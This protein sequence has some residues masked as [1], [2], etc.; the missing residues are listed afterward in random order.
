MNFYDVLGITHSASKE[1]I[2]KAYHR[3]ILIYHPDKCSDYDSKDKF[4]EIQ[5]AYEILYDDEKRKDYDNMTTE[6]KHQ[7]YDLVKQYFT[8]IRPEYLYMYTSM[9]N[10]VYG[11]EKGESEF[12]T[13]INNLNIKGFIGKIIEKVKDIY[14]KKIINVEGNSYDLHVSLKD[15][16]NN[17]MKNI[18]IG[19]NSYIV[20]V[21]KNQIIIDDIFRGKVNIN[22]IY[23]R[24]INYKVID[25]SNL[26]CVKIVSLSQYIYGG[27]V[28]IYDVNLDIVWLEFDSCLERKPVFVIKNRGLPFVGSDNDQRGDL[29]VYLVIE[30]INTR[31]NSD[32]NSVTENY[33]VVVEDTLKLIFP[34]IE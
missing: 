31:V 4:Q 14:G 6:E 19:D 17:K 3:L 34:P 27:K 13:D 32:E 20:P 10:F 30:G 8:Q 18:K 25:D 28:K 26:F 22:I 5:A 2:K 16:Y 7:L 1:E 23:D 21:H 29:F 9:I 15:R 33:R 24:D 12:Q 11:N